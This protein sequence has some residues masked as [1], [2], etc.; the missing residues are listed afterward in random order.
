MSRNIFLKSPILAHSAIMSTQK[1]PIISLENVQFWPKIYLILTPQ[2]RNSKTR[3]TLILTFLGKNL[4]IHAQCQLRCTGFSLVKKQRIKT[5]SFFIGITNFPIFSF[6]NSYCYKM[7]L[8][9]VMVRIPNHCTL[10]Y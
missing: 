3:L 4:W 5:I 1:T 2:S 9:N 7:K 10:H 6:L 8:L